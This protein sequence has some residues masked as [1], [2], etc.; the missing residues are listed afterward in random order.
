MTEDIP[1]GNGI[2]SGYYFAYWTINGV[3]QAGVTGTALTKV[4]LL[5]TND[6]T[7]IA[8][9]FPA[10]DNPDNGFFEVHNG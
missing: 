3:R 7:A 5:M 2:V 1:Y 4:S 6:V 10:G 9:F 8:V